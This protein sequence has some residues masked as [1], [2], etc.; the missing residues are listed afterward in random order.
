MAPTERT[1][2]A[3]WIVPVDRPPLPHGTVTIRDGMIVAI[4][5]HGTRKPDTDLG[6]VA[7]LPGLVNA[8]THLDLCGLKNLLK[9]GPDFTAWLR[10]VIQHRRSRAP[11]VVQADIRAGIDQCIANGTTLVGDISAGGLSW[12][13]LNASSLGA[14][15]FYEILGLPRDRAR[16]AW[17]NASA[18]LAQH[19]PSGRCRPGLSPHAPYS[20]RASLFR[21]ALQH[22]RRNGCLVATHFAESRAEL[23]LLKNHEGPFIDFLTEIGVFD[24]DGL[25][26]S[27]AELLCM[28]RLARSLLIHAN[29]LSPAEL[30]PGDTIVYCPRTHAAFGHA[31]YPLSA[32]LAAGARIALGTDSLAS[33]PDLSVLEEARFV[34]RHQ[35]KIPPSEILG[36]ATLNG[37]TALG[38]S[39]S[40]G[41]IAPGKAAEFVL[42]EVPERT[43]DPC[44][45]ILA[46]SGAARRHGYADSWGKLSP[47]G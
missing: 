5:P 37:A 28:T 17:R 32:F 2:T 45:Q 26:E 1:L 25:L 15:V 36:M 20:V 42:V 18:W 34:Y 4:E 3:Q 8:H 9:P 24:R 43:G 6:N 33:N 13:A 38:W 47:P 27:P 46:G 22:A 11:Q 21:I 31:P 29:Y 19:P 14:V 39:D 16:E 12:D 10:A 35:P 40:H 44:E 23:E 30:K 7:V 41:S